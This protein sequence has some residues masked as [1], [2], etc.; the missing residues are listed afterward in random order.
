[1]CTEI[2]IECY[3]FVG[4]PKQIE[5]RI[6]VG[7]FLMNPEKWSVVV[8]FKIYTAQSKIRIQNSIAKESSSW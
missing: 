8:N 5:I 3:P 2:V 7:L 6:C 1:M 4:Y